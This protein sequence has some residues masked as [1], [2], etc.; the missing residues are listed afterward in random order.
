MGQRRGYRNRRKY[1]NMKQIQGYENYKITEDGVVYSSYT[2]SVKKPSNHR[3]GYFLIGLIKDNKEKKLLVHRLVAMTY[4]EN[5]KGYKYVNHK[6]GDKKNNHVTNLE[7][8]TSSDNQKHAYKTGLKVA[9]RKTI[10]N[11]IVINSENGVFYNSIKEASLIYGL[12]K[13]HLAQML[14]GQIRNKT[15][16]IYAK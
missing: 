15:N 7:W 14:R 12:E 10:N 3:Q 8:V 13:S 2:N 11:K 16:L 1:I 9:S 6:D 5:P 4:L